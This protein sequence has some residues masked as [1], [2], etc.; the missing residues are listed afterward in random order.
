M[1]YAVTLTTSS[2]ISATFA[3][4]GGITFNGMTAN[5]PVILSRNGNIVVVKTSGHTGN[6]GSRNS[7]LRT[8][9]PGTVTVYAVG[10][11]TPS[12]NVWLYP[13][14]GYDTVRKSAA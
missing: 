5:K 4:D 13:L 12:G 6:P 2:R 10:E 11:A 14:G 3:A 7:G 1:S 9:Y 8:Y